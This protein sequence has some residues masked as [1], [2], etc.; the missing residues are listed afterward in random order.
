MLVLSRKVGERIVIGDNVTVVINRIVGSR[1]S[2]GIEAPTDVRIVRGELAPVVSAFERDA[3]APSASNPVGP[4]FELS[5][6][7]AVHRAR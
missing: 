2:V 1:V 3:S 4:T 5:A 7:P 6:A